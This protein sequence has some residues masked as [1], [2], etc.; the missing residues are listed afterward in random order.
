[1]SILLI[2]LGNLNRVYGFILVHYYM[3]GMGI[4]WREKRKRK[5]AD[6]ILRFAAV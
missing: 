2:G 1:M 3:K 4:L 6:F 5:A